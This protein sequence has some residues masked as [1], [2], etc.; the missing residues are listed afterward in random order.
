MGEGADSTE[1]HL[2]EADAELFWSDAGLATGQIGPHQVQRILRKQ[3]ECHLSNGCLIEMGN[4]GISD[5]AI[6]RTAYLT[7]TR[8]CSGEDLSSDLRRDGL[9]H[10]HGF[11]RPGGHI[12][13]QCGQPRFEL[14][15]PDRGVSG[16]EPS[17][18]RDVLPPIIEL[19]HTAPRL[20]V[21]EC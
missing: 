19:E 3:R 11:R 21:I 2:L 13:R 16:E 12:K 17:P 10:G 1:G 20:V 5:Q 14:L 18:L 6:S 9:H 7:R 4:E 8:I 15:L